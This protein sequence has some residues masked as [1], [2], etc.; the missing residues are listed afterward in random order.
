[1]EIIKEEKI[2]EVVSQLKAYANIQTELLKLRT[3]EKA[4]VSGAFVSAR[5]FIFF[6]CF[7]S[8]I[9]LGI[10][11]S[12]YL[13]QV[14][15]SMVSGFTLVG[16]FYLLLT[17]VLLLLKNKILETPVKNKIIYTLSDPGK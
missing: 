15:G 10:A 7:I 6:S 1:M 17:L 13:A 11:A 8:L 3:I 12:F 14:L 5:F 9:F 16:A 4:A 2:E